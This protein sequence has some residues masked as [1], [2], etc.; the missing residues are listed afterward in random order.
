MRKLFLLFFFLHAVTEGYSQVDMPTGGAVFGM[1]MLNWQDDK[2]RLNLNVSLNY[3][4][5]NGL[6]VNAIA[7]NVGQGW[8]LEAGGVITRMQAGE[9][10][11]QKPRDGDGTPEDITRYPAGALYAT[12]DVRQ[13]CPGNMLRYP[14]YKDQNHLYK[15][16]NITSEDKELDQFGFSF[17]GRSGIFILTKDGNGLLLGDATLKIWYT[18]D[19]NAAAAANSRTTINSFFIQDENG[20]IYEFSVQERAKALKT[21]YC[22]QN[23]QAYLTQP[24]FQSGHMYFESSFDDNDPS[25]PQTIPLVNPWVTTSWYLKTIT[26]PLTNRVVTFNYDISTITNSSAIALSYMANKNYTT[27]THTTSITQTPE[28]SS[29][30]Y[31]D[32]HKILFGYGANRFDNPGEKALASI[33]IQYND[34]HLSEYLLTT[35]Y[36]IRNRYGT[37]T[38]ADQIQSARLCLLSVQRIG[39]DLRASEPPYR[40]DYYLGSSNPYD[41]V[42]PPFYYMKDIWGYYNGNLSLDAASPSGQPID[43]TTN[44]F[45]LT[46]QQAKGLCYVNDADNNNLSDPNFIPRLY[47]VN[48][49]YAKNGLLKRIYYPSG[50]TLIYQY[51]QNK[52]T[53]GGQYRNVGGVHV[54]QTQ[55]TDG[56][57]SNGCNNPLLTSYNYT[58]DLTNSQSSM[59]IMEAP[60]NSMTMENVYEAES[61]HAHYSFPATVTWDYN[62]KFPGILSRDQAVSLSGSQKFW[63]S[64]SK[65]MNVVGAVMDVIDIVNI[66]LDATPAA[67]LAVALDVIGSVVGFVVGAF[68]DLS[69]DIN[70]LFF[71]NS[72]INGGNPL[73]MGF[74]RLQVVGGGGGDGSVVYN[75]TNPNESQFAVWQPTNPSMAMI[76]RYGNW[77]YGLAETI[78]VYDKDNNIV[79]QTINDYNAT[80]FAYEYRGPGHQLLYDAL[81]CKCLIAQSQSWRHDDWTNANVA[82]DP[83]TYTSSAINT[84]ATVTGAGGKTAMLILPY[85]YYY[86]RMELL[87]QQESIY[88]P[89]DQTQ[90]QT[91]STSYQYN[92]VNFL[93]NVVTKILSNGD[94]MYK[95]MTYPSDFVSPGSDYSSQGILGTMMTNNMVC[96]PITTRNE[97][98]HRTDQTNKNGLL[99]EKVTEYTQIVTGAI[100]PSRILEQRFNSPAATPQYYAGPGNA[101]NPTYD[102]IGLFSYAANGGLIGIIDEGGRQ[103]TNIYDYNDKYVVASVINA[104]AV[105][106]MPAYT[107][108]ESNSLGGWQLTGSG[109]STSGSAVTGDHYFPLSGGT[110]TAP[111]NIGKAYTVSFWSTSSSVTAL[112]GSLVRSA[113]TINGYTYYEYLLPAG[114]TTARVTG[115]GNID[116]L[117]LYPSNAKMRTS[118]YDVVMGKTASCDE[119]NRVSSVTYDDL[120]RVQFVK[121]EYGNVLKMYEYS[122]ADNNGAACLTTYTNNAITEQFVRQTCPSGYQGLPKTYTIAAGKYTSTI[123]QAA[124]DQQAQYELDQLGQAAADNQD[125]TTGCALLYYNTAVSQSFVDQNCSVG[126]AGN[127]YTY[128]VPAN[129]YSSTISA[130]DAQQQAIDDLNANGQS[131]ANLQ[132]NGCAVDNTSDWES[133]GVTTCLS[134]GHKELQFQDINPNSSTYNQLML[135]DIGASSD[136][137]VS[138]YAKITYINQ[139]VDKTSN[140]EFQYT[141]ADIKV[142]FYADAGLTQ[143]YSVANLAVS[144]HYNQNC[145]QGSPSSSQVTTVTINGTSAILATNQLIKSLQVSDGQGGLPTDP[146]NCT[147][148]FVLDLGNY[149]IA[150]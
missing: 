50:G 142:S 121:D 12:V 6:K 141:S 2:S 1:P 72:D 99:S 39:V 20:L 133:T 102:Q 40:F 51:D 21:K 73:P 30:I 10:D 132:S 84:L 103:A 78:T 47:N 123:S 97:Y 76:Q 69:K 139:S 34:R 109:T 24:N 111:L 90:K 46:P 128:T 124:A 5:G 25:N 60:R 95:T 150:N 93:P 101:N 41:F 140:P 59:Y 112:G 143:P 108:F 4:S 58:S 98:Y 36:F 15:N 77:E 127:T 94:I 116:E 149:I 92:A 23:Q 62:F 82:N 16:Y 81:S 67:V 118:T 64:F 32:G 49:N 42:P 88:K 125:G 66:S 19:E 44:V 55:I 26:D 68:T 13:G 107:S 80:K 3:S 100:K 65:V 110:F 53:V 130:D 87:D 43:P 104:D 89:G 96:E 83:S 11:D 86:G 144:W 147:Y 54:T 45:K 38:S 131:W 71:Y 33:D 56:G 27:I 7:S 31:P 79:K 106:D 57:F 8:D 136:C 85:E 75:Y 146:Y 14:I 105:L 115:N 28:Y 17:N 135:V 119:N 35:S 138:I 129:K 37:P 113:P 22:N 91:T 63:L 117:R 126:Y 70:E 74:S 18:K 134:N 48:A 137:A 120:G 61:K 148:D 114:A 9:P 29:I 52:G 145:T 122:Y